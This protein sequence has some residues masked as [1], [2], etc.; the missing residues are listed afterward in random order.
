MTISLRYRLIGCITLLFGITGQMQETAQAQ[1]P[2]R[3]PARISAL[4]QAGNGD[5]ST[6]LF[7]RFVRPSRPT[8]P[9]P[10]NSTPIP[11]RLV[12]PAQPPRPGAGGL[13][14]GQ[15]DLVIT[16]QRI[17]SQVVRDGT[18]FKVPVVLNVR[19]QG[20]AD[21]S[22]FNL[23][24]Y[25]AL[26]VG[27]GRLPQRI[28][29]FTH[30]TYFRLANGQPPV[31]Q[32]LAAGKSVMV[33]GHAY[34][35]VTST[36]LDRHVQL[37]AKADVGGSIEHA[38]PWGSV[39]ESREDN[40]WSDGMRVY[41][42]SLPG[43]DSAVGGG[44]VSPTVAFDFEL[45]AQKIEEAC[46]GNCVGYGYAIIHG[47]RVVA[48]GAGGWARNEHNPPA[49]QFS[50]NTRLDLA[51]CTKFLTAITTLDALEKRGLTVEEPIGNW[52]PTDW[53]VHPDVAK[54]TFRQVLAHQS[55]LQKIGGAY[56]DL[57]QTCELPPTA[58][59]GYNN[60]NYALMRIC[61]PYLRYRNTL[62]AKENDDEQSAALTADCFLY[63]MRT[64][65]A[66]KAGLP[67]LEMKP[68]GVPESQ[69]PANYKFPGT[70]AGYIDGDGT[71]QSGP[72]QATLSAKEL[73]QVCSALEYGKLL[74][75]AMKKTM[76]DNQ[77]GIFNSGGFYT[78]NGG[79]SDGQGR[80]VGSR[81]VI[82]PGDVQ[83]AIIVNS[84]SNTLP[85]SFSIVKSAYDAAKQ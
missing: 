12:R 1:T 10:D 31:V 80:G 22:Y 21:A 37:R 61:E 67:G 49:L 26:P 8:P 78:H 76:K 73:A 11:P 35:P 7:P 82:C 2:T 57:Q 3:Q 54:L 69:F 39:K 46:E 84:S 5:A 33:I 9:P 24:V 14:A 6:P 41:L 56:G 47:R 62:L 48:S 63:D 18:K 81:L 36:L 38:Q 32:K 15:P 71:W 27:A 13:T 43:K 65:V 74:S 70:S 68:W 83:V 17:G 53:N 23:G 30:L 25:Y 85:E 19:N 59:L 64:F 42:P 77:L 79:A 28:E 50:A 75:P 16:E 55:G 29:K 72:G 44:I 40:N 4:R 58:A 51:S 60:V 20:A 66:Q 52:L 45:F 34:L